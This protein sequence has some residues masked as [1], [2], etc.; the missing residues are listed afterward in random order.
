[1]LH[2]MYVLQHFASTILLIS[3]CGDFCENIFKGFLN[4]CDTLPLIIMNSWVT[5]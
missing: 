3:N 4:L 1:M 2:A 5:F